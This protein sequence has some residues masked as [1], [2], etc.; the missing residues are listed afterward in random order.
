MEQDKLYT[1]QYL[2]TTGRDCRI[3]V[4]DLN[5]LGDQENLEKGQDAKF[6][7]YRKFNDSELIWTCEYLCN[8]KVEG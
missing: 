2:I 5:K 4:W 8:K 3:R 1:Q 6:Y 7:Q